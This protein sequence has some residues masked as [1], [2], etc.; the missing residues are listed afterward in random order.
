[1]PYG[2]YALKATYQR[3]LSLAMGLTLVGVAL[4]VIVSY[5]WPTTPKIT[6][7]PGDRSLP[8]LQAFDLTPPPS[9]AY[10]TP[11]LT[12]AAAQPIQRVEFGTPVPVRDELIADS[13]DVVI[14]SPRDIAF[15]MGPGGID[16]FSG[17]GIDTTAIIDFIPKP[18]DWVPHEIEPQLVY[19]YRGDYP[20]FA[21]MAGSEGTVAVYVYIDKEGRPVEARVA[22]S[23]GTESLD[24]AAVA[25][26]LKCSF[27][28]GIQNGYP[29][30]L[31]VVISYVFKLQ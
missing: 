24:E 19:Q 20:R 31:W 8:V 14:A 1:M 17:M 6:I 21:R 26:A 12:V 27:S 22:R 18:T 16:D 9:I 7:G 5:L 10:E 11:E 30:A 29:V 13:Q 4:V 3:N 15:R 25:W 23:S 2:A 28:P